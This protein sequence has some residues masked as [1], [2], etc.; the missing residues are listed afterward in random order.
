MTR[1]P[2]DEACIRAFLTRLGG[3]T[4]IPVRLYLVGGATAVLEGWRPS[5]TDIDLTFEPDVR[6][7]Y[8][9]LPAL[10]EQL[11]LNIEIAAPSHFLPELPG[12]RDRS[13]FVGQYGLLTALHYDA[14]A[15]CL[16][17]IE[18]GHAQDLGDVRH[19]LDGGLVDPALLRELFERIRPDLVRFPALEPAVL[20]AK[21]ELALR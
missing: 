18:R 7:V 9:A 3:A 1:R 5:T 20:E 17:K 14:Y 16:A 10:K 12:W 8:E 6:E 11:Q 21:L 19:M 2:A 15:Q 13:R 4:H